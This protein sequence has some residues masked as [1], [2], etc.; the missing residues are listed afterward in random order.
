MTRSPASAGAPPARTSASSRGAAASPALPFVQLELA[1]TVGLEDGRY[2]VRTPAGSEESEHVLVVRIAGAPPPSRRRLSRAK[3]KPSD[4]DPEQP[5][6]PLT[7]LTVITAAALG[8]AES[9]D[10]WLDELRE[11]PDKLTAELSAALVLINRAIH[12]HRAAVLDPTLADVDAERALVARVGFGEGEQLADGRFTR[13]IEVPRSARARQAEALRPQERLAAVL[14]GRETVAACEL[15]ILRARTDLDAGRTREAAL[16]L[17]VGLEALL[18]ERDSLRAP[19]EDEDLAAL[20]ARRRLTGDAA[21]VALLGEL[22]D[23]RVA[24]VAETLRL[25]ERILRRKRALG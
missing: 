25:C 23:E 6:V 14:G 18:A 1:G 8:E 7:T 13:A 19:G 15:L 3:P 21:N 9:A 16:Q 17:R 24:E 5:T 4:P 2:L 20:D 12:V 10:R 22:G 11:D